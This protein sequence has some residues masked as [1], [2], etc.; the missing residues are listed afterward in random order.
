MDSGLSEPV[1]ISETTPT[2]V[3]AV[4]REDVG[5]LTVALSASRPNQHYE[6]ARAF[7]MANGFRP[8]EESPELWGP[9]NPALHMIKALGRRE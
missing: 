3:A 1:G 7:Y 5:L 6:R 9:H 4:D 2:S 8:L